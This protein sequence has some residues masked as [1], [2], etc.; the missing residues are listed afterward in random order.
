MACTLGVF[1]ME[2][3]Q[4]IGTKTLKAVPMTR[5]HYC[6]YRGWKVPENENKGD[7][8]Y[9]VEYTDGGQPNDERHNGYISWSPKDVFEKSY[10]RYDAEGLEPHQ[11]RV[12]A[13]KAQLDDRISKLR[14]FIYNS[15]IFQ[16]LPEGEKERL[17]RQK[18]LMDDLSGVLDER[19]L[20]FGA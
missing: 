19:M 12:A 9:L 3:Q 17:K 20:A 15:E 7:Y 13:E 16:N 5:G 18:C 1:K 10:V 4:Y 14:D 2:M 6:D 11:Q 8:G